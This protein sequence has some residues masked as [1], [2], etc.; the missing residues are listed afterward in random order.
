M[1]DFKTIQ[2]Y[3]CTYHVNSHSSNAIRYA[4]SL[5]LW[6]NNMRQKSHS[7]PDRSSIKIETAPLSG[8]GPPVSVVH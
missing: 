5:E 7:L 2:I 3:I 4:R 6:K 8:T 1:E